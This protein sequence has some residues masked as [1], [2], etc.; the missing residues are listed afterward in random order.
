MNRTRSLS[1]APALDFKLKRRILYYCLPRR[2]RQTR[3]FKALYERAKRLQFNQTRTCTRRSSIDIKD[4]YAHKINEGYYPREWRPTAK[5]GDKFVREIRESEKLAAVPDL[6][7]K[8]V[9]I[10]KFVR[11]SGR[12]VRGYSPSRYVTPDSSPD[13]S[14]FD[15]VE[16]WRHGIEDPEPELEEDRESFWSCVEVEEEMARFC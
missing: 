2:L 3:L 8:L 13:Y 14:F 7:N 9:E 16:R 6:H 1:A 4:P 15:A 10:E 5:D 11:K 12:R